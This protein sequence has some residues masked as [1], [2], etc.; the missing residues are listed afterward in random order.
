MSL[1]KFLK[2]KF[3]SVP[4]WARGILF[5]FLAGLLACTVPIILFAVLW[6]GMI[7]DEDW[8]EARLPTHLAQ[9]GLAPLS[10]NDLDASQV[11]REIREAS[12]DGNWTFTA[13]YRGSTGYDWALRDKNGKVFPAI[14]VNDD[15]PWGYPAQLIVL[16]SPDSR[17]LA[18]T[19]MDTYR[20]Q[21][22]R[23]IDLS[24]SAPRYCSFTTSNDSIEE[25]QRMTIS[26]V[27]SHLMYF[28]TRQSKALRWLSDNEL[29]LLAYKV[30]MLDTQPAE[31][32]TVAR[33][34]LRFNGSTASIIQSKELFHD[35]FITDL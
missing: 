6:Y 11:P 4:R 28:E 15:G 24:G 34:I 23:V 14:A 1:Y 32:H 29:E 8:K 12:P 26:P 31:T 13:S 9:A 2:T 33:E 27:A 35:E 5:L 16:W 17:H 30:A 19:D 10:A 20:G 22:V 21:H 18:I 7:L 25:S 3:L